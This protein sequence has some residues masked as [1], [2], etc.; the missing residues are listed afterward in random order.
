MVPGQYNLRP[1]EKHKFTL[2]FEPKTIGKV[3]TSQ[4]LLIN[5]LYEI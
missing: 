4:M 5:K 3:D 2:V 1:N